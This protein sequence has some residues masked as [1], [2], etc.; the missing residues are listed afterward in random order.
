MLMCKKPTSSKRKKEGAAVSGD[1]FYGFQTI[2][3]EHLNYFP[4]ILCAVIGNKWLLVVINDKGAT[5]A[6]VPGGVSCVSGL[7]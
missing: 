4:M 1:C 6:N 7:G 3:N 2:P 5:F